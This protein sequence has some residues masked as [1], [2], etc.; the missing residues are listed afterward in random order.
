MSTPHTNR[1]RR[2][3]AVDILGICVGSLLVDAIHSRSYLS[4]LIAAALLVVLVVVDK[5]NISEEEGE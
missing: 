2:H 3:I 4:G 1:S 5:M